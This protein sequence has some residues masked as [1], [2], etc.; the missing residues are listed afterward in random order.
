MYSKIV[1]TMALTSIPCYASESKVS[2][3]QNSHYHDYHGYVDC[4]SW[5]AYL[6]HHP[7]YKPYHPVTDIKKHGCNWGTWVTFPQK[8]EAIQVRVGHI[9]TPLELLRSKDFLV[10]YKHPHYYEEAFFNYIVDKRYTLEQ[11]KIA[12]YAMSRHSYPYWEKFCELYK[13]KE[14]ELPLLEL[15]LAIHITNSFND[16]YCKITLTKEIKRVSPTL[17]RIQ[18]NIPKDSSL[19][20]HLKSIL[21]DSQLPKSWHKYR[22]HDSGDISR[23][24]YTAD[25]P[26][27]DI[28]TDAVREADY[29]I[30]CNP[31]D[32]EFRLDNYPYFLMVM[33]HPVDYYPAHFELGPKSKKE[34][35][36]SREHTSGI[37]VLRYKG[38]TDEEKSMTIFGMSQL[39]VTNSLE[40]SGY[41][42]FMIDHAIE[43]YKLG[44]LSVHHLLELFICNFPTFY[45]YPFFI[46]DYKEE[47]IQK[48]LNKFIAEPTIPEGIKEVAR[49]VK[50]GTLA[51]KEEMNYMQGYRTFRKTHFTLYETIVP[52]D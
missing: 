3:K 6:H 46:L 48:A 16:C 4:H 49:K 35:D 45:K 39:G 9:S 51:T 25:L 22:I 15:M 11:K 18:N 28:L 19:H 14:I 30:N 2:A 50:D 40:S 1:L 42:A 24:Y 52:R 8:I 12:A 17:E 43:W 47:A 41:Y 29:V 26:F 21:V 5:A 38:Y 32:S 7:G 31:G 13:K 10:I 36:T 34:Q 27:Y 44:N 23:G 37:D 33:E 20:H